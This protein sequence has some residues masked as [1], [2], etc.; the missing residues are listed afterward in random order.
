M[1]AILGDRFRRL[2]EAGRITQRIA[3]DAIHAD[4]SKISRLE[5]GHTHFHQDDAAV[6][7]D[8][9]GVPADD[10]AR[11][12]TW[13]QRVNGASWPDYDDTDADS[14]LDALL[15]D[16][17]L[18]LVRGYEH[19]VIP[20]LLQTREYANA[21]LRMSREEMCENDADA[22]LEL[23]MRGQ[24]MLFAQHPPAVWLV[25]EKTALLRPI[26]DTAMWHRQIDHLLTLA[27]L[28]HVTVQLLDDAAC[29]PARTGESFTYL[30]FR[31][32]RLRELVRTQQLSGAICR[33]LPSETEPYLRTADRLAM[34]AAAPRDSIERI[35]ELRRRAPEPDA[36]PGPGA[37]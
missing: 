37:G 9:Y 27:E 21:A 17:P 15:C 5:S 25:V 36:Q 34:L 2:R 4:T 35:S 23:R 18:Q 14:G 16:V 7:L 8:L 33:D 24:R 29:G 22:V 32:F 3:G 19:G 10:R 20:A 1:P 13:A 30:R 12:L 6:L 28:P 11:Y 26:V 31:N